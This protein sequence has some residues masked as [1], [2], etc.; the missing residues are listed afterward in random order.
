MTGITL[1]VTIN[2]TAYIIT[3]LPEDAAPDTEAARVAAN[4][5]SA[6]AYADRLAEPGTNWLI[7]SGNVEPLPM[8]MTPTE[9]CKRCGGTREVPC[10]PSKIW[11]SKTRPCPDCLPPRGGPVAHARHPDQLV[12]SAP[13]T[14]PPPK[15]R[16]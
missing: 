8:D 12:P 11:R 1:N 15:P 9:V 16:G 7:P 14:P 6:R 4:V 2:G 5:A 13:T 10:K 3:G